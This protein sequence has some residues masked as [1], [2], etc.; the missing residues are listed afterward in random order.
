MT[1]HRSKV[2]VDL[3]VFARIDVRVTLDGH[4]P[5]EVLYTGGILRHVFQAIEPGK[6]SVHV[7]DVMGF[8]ESWEIEVG[9]PTP[10]SMPTATPIPDPTATPIPVATSEE[11]MEKALSEH[12][13]RYS[14]PPYPLA[15]AP[16]REIW[17]RD[18]DL[19]R[20]LAQAPWIADGLANWEDDA[21]Y[22]LG[23][24]GD[25]DPALARRIFAYTMEEP[26]RSRNTL[27]LSTLGH[28]LSEHRETFELL[29]SRPWFADGLDA[30]ERAFITAVSHTTGVDGL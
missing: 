1:A 13:P 7:N 25:Y 17:Q 5:D 2:V 3:Q 10:A 23:H 21:V 11:L 14:D 15:L 4:E 20:E 6:R 19:G 22:G 24:L 9:A 12:I 26:V 30:V 28:M 18:S 27:L 29:I 16:I 8:S